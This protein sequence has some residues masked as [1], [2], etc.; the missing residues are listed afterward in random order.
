MWPASYSALPPMCS[1]DEAAVVHV[2]RQPADVHEQRRAAFCARAGEASRTIRANESDCTRHRVPPNG[3]L[4]TNGAMMTGGGDAHQRGLQP[5]AGPCSQRRIASARSP[6]RRPLAAEFGRLAAGALRTG[7][8][9]R[10]KRAIGT[11]GAEL[12]SGKRTSDATRCRRDGWPSSAPRR[13]PAWRWRPRRRRTSPC[14]AMGIRSCGCSR[15]S[16]RAGASGRS[17][18]RGRSAS[19]GRYSL[20][21][22]GRARR[23]ADARARRRRRTD[24]GLVSTVSAR[25]VLQLPAGP[26]QPVVG[27]RAD[28]SARRLVSSSSADARSRPTSAPGASSFAR[29]SSKPS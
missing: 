10:Y 23:A 24:D 29:R 8:A 22:P 1:S 7:M 11:A 12:L 21:A 14:S 9:G 18:R 4:F 28:R 16:W 19:S 26:R 20:V 6:R 2:L 25:G 15:G 13:R 27:S 5:E 3:C 17:S